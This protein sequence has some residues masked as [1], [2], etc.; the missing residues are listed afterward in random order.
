MSKRIVSISIVGSGRVGL[1][2]LVLTSCWCSL[3]GLGDGQFHNLGD[4]LA[5]EVLALVLLNQLLHVLGRAVLGRAAMHLVRSHNSLGSLFAGIQASGHLTN[6]EAGLVLLFKVL[7]AVGGLGLSVAL[8]ILRHAGG[9]RLLVLQVLLRA[10][11][12]RGGF[13]RR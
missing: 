6:S 13:G 3:T 8:L 11:D 5:T 12:G 2:W 1:C 10:R 9:T 7:V 4:S